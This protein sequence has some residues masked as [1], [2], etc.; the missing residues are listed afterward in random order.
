MNEI[1]KIIFISCVYSS[2]DKYY[3]IK[4]TIFLYIFIYKNCHFKNNFWT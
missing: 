3:T 2:Y 4:V 1:E